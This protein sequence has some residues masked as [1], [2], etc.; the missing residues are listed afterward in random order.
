MTRDANAGV[1]P[2]Y[3]F[4]PKRFGYGAS[5]A[6]WKGVV[7][8]LVFIGVSITLVRLSVP[9]HPAFLSLLV[10]LVAGFVWLSKVKTDGDWRWRSG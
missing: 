10:P 3:W 2:G 9:A 7:A 1:R 8:V 5:P 6:N 4:R